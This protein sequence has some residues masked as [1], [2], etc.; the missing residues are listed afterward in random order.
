VAPRLQIVS[1]VELEGGYGERAVGWLLGC[2]CIVPG[3]GCDRWLLGRA[4]TRSFAQFA[5]AHLLDLFCC[6]AEAAAGHSLL[7]K[8]PDEN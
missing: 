1:V 3:S 4:L 6:G 5:S 7:I 8:W 2:R